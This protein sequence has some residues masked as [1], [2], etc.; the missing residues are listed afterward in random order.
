MQSL[1]AHRARLHSSNGQITADVRVVSHLVRIQITLLVFQSL[2][3]PDL[4]VQT[5]NSGISGTFN[6]SDT[7]KITTSNAPI[8]VNVNLESNDKNR[9]TAVHMRTSNQ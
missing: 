5:S 6:T 1:T 4:T 9:P 7:L 8:K 3:S 2:I